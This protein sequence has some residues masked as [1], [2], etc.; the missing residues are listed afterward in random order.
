MRQ[1]EANLTALQAIGPRKKQKLDNS[2]S[3]GVSGSGANSISSGLNR[4][5]HLRPRIK[6]VSSRD[7]HFL[8]EQEKETCRSTTLYKFYLKWWSARETT[9]IKSPNIWL[10]TR[11][12]VL[13]VLVLLDLLCQPG[14]ARMFLSTLAH[15]KHCRKGTCA[16]PCFEKLPLDVKSLLVT[17][18]IFVCPWFNVRFVWSNKAWTCFSYEEWLDVAQMLEPR[19]FVWRYSFDLERHWMLSRLFLPLWRSLLSCL[20][21]VA[22]EC[23]QHPK[24]KY[25]FQISAHTH[26]CNT[27]FI[28]TDWA[29]SQRVVHVRSLTVC[30]E[31]KIWNDDYLYGNH[32]IG[33]YIDDSAA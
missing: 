11:F 14:I 18:G 19:H 13:R 1:R 22:L 16:W 17:E 29:H 2:G 9:V 5:I 24:E 7:L 20:V 8:M 25:F 15:V 10:S 30:R 12:M 6:R 31:M 28:A 3:L 26:S 21:K 32:A 27:R 4:Q 33:K 23:A